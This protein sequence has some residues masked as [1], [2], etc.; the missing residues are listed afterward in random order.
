MR[1]RSTGSVR[2][3]SHAPERVMMP[4]II[5]PQEGAIRISEKTMPRLWA[6]SGRAV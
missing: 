5:P 4:L 1:K 2:S 3:F 6:Q